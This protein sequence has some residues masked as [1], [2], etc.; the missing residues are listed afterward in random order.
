[1]QVSSLIN[2]GRKLGETIDNLE[3]IWVSSI[4]EI[5]RQQH[6]LNVCYIQNAKLMIY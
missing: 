1:M 5:I 2:P 6:L 4:S 3:E